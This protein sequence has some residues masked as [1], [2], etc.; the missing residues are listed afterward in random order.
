MMKPLHRWIGLAGV[1]GAG[2]VQAAINPAD[3]H[4]QRWPTASTTFNKPIGV[5]HAN[6]GSGRA[7]VIEKCGEIHIV[8]NGAVLPTPFADIAVN[9]G[10]NEQGLLGL[11]FDPDY[12]NNGEFYVS[13]TAPGTGRHTLERYT[14]SSNPDVANPTGTVI[15]SVPDIASN[16]NGGDVQFGPDGYLYWS[17]GDGGAQGDPNGFAQ[18]TGRKKQD[19]NPASCYDVSGSS[20]KYYLLGT[21]VRLDVHATTAAA[22]NLCGVAAGQAAPYAIPPG[23][24][25]ANPT[26]HPDDCAEIFNW[27]FR[28]PYRFSFD[29]E[30][31]DM[32]IA[33]VGQNRY[34]E[35]DFQAAG[36]GGQNFQWNQ[37]E[38]NHTYPGNAAGCAGPSGSVPPRIELSQNANGV[39]AV[40][41]GYVYR[42]P[43]TP[44][45]GQYLFSDNCSGKLYVVANP[46]A[47]LPSWTFEAVPGTPWVSS[48]SFGEDEAGNVYLAGGGGEV[49]LVASAA[50]DLIFAN[51]FDGTGP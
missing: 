44:L 37:C 8:R 47:G 20:T 12:A 10:G 29:R 18:C 7:F 41:G 22:Q 28:N 30:T 24:P 34:E 15:L 23:N 1:L 25:F 26:T 13:Y 9:C 43:I 16:H 21:I 19:G 6:D 40:I 14:V 39:C 11:A 48:Y 33:D 46:A 45:R 32:V 38:G 3:L 51:G 31:G 5:H 50:I 27:G 17:I 4:L 42:G 49:Y 2:L 36:S 35:I